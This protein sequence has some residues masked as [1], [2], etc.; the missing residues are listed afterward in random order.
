MS[1]SFLKKFVLV[2]TKHRTGVQ[3]TGFAGRSFLSP[4]AS[5]LSMQTG[6]S[7]DV[8]VDN[9]PVDLVSAAARRATRRRFRYAIR[10]KYFSRRAISPAVSARR[11]PRLRPV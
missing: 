7:H 11:P 4:S 9:V 1:G 6:L 5:L 8:V 3:C 10:S 2:T